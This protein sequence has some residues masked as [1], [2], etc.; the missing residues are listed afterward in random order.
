[1]TPERWRQIREVLAQ[2]L[3]LAP[4]ERAPFLDRACS[5]DPSLRQEVET[6]L[7]SSPNALIGYPGWRSFSSGWPS[8]H[9]F[10]D[11]DR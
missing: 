6:L 4:G 1:M 9:Q 10:A 7:A 8:D 11:S 2:A 3:D 5:S